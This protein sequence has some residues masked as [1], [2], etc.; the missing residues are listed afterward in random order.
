VY[1]AR[2]TPAGANLLPSRF[3]PAQFPL[4]LF[5]SSDSIAKQ[6]HSQLKPPHICTLH[7][8]G[9]RT[10]PRRSRDGM[11]EG[12]RWR[13][14]LEKVCPPLDQVLKFGAPIAMP[15]TKASKSHAFGQRAQP[16]PKPGNSMLTPQAPFSD[17]G[18]PSLRVP[19]GHPAT[20]TARAKQ[21]PVTE[22]GPSSEHFILN[23]PSNGRKEVDGRSDIFSLDRGAYEML[24]GRRAFEARATQRSIGI[25][26]KEPV[27]DSSVND[28]RRRGWDHAVKNAWQSPP[29]NVGQSASDLATR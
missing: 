24:T 4:D 15:S 6:N 21:S 19:F 28:E 11:L 8:I 14:G 27:P 5:G 9:I 1:R 23:S 26:E 3:C 13:S 10:S 18:P 20:L 16:R 7:D 29:M 17:F 2:D 22:Q 25:L 12:G